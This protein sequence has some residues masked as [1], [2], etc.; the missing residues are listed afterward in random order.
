MNGFM[1]LE[2]VERIKKQYPAGTRI[3][4]DC[5]SDDPRPIEPGTLGTVLGVDDAGSI[6]MKWDNGRLLSLIP[7][8]DS[9]HVIQQKEELKLDKLTVSEQ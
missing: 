3:C 2:Q 6:M 1:R 4:C 9:F 5:M 7:G 8:V